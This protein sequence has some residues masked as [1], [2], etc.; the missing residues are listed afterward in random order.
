MM[1]RRFLANAAGAVVRSGAWRPSPSHPSADLRGGH[2]A[3]QHSIA[4]TRPRRWSNRYHASRTQLN[5]EEELRACSQHEL[6][7]I[8]QIL[9]ANS[10]DVHDDVAQMLTRKRR[11]T[12][13]GA[14]PSPAAND[15]IG[16]E[17]GRL[18]EIGR[19]LTAL[20][21]GRVSARQKVLHA[22]RLTALGA[23]ERPQS[24]T[25]V[26]SSLGRCGE[27][28]PALDAFD[29]VPSPNAF[30]FG[31]AISAC[32]VAGRSERA[33][34]LV[35]EAKRRGVVPDRVMYNATISACEKGALWEHALALLNEMQRTGV[36]P[37]VVSYSA[38]ISACGKG[39]QCDP[40]LALF[41]EM[42]RRQIEPDA[43]IYNATISACE[44]GAR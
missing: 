28:D 1:L 29:M 23:L 2:I 37:D 10:G 44:K 38:A 20:K 11:R 22:R 21:D 43:T 34:E 12:Q 14:P 33:L 30:T 27:V 25:I 31:A 13:P 36:E 3:F 39:G 15:E 18:P 4:G 26:I 6:L 35:D 16:R 24:A 17:I 41:D 9:V 19:L 7:E 8:V 32:A 42:K 5:V 40:A